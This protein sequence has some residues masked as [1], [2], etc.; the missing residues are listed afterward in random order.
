MCHTRIYPTTQIMKR[1]ITQTIDGEAGCI[2]S[3]CEQYR[4]RLWREWDASRPGLG[5]IML[6]PSTADHQVNDPT[7][8]RCLQRALAGKYGR[9]GRPRCYA[10]SGYAAVLLYHLGLYKD[11]SP[12]H[13]LYIA[14]KV[15]PQPFAA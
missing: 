13:L 8:T 15:Q 10:S 12:K 9:R 4:H 1:L 11:G 6:N 2:L 7:I 5:F 3:D 14:A